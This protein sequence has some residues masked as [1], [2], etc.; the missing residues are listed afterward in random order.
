MDRKKLAEEIVSDLMSTAEPTSPRKAPRRKAVPAQTIEGDGNV[1]AGGGKALR[2]TIKGNGNVQVNGG[3]GSMTIRSTRAP[4]IEIAPAPGSIGADGV[5]KERVKEAFGALGTEREKRFGKSAYQ[6]MYSTFKKDFSIPKELP[7]TAIWDW[8]ASRADEVVAYLEAKYG[9]TIA[10][11]IERAA[12]KPGYQ[13]TRG[14]LFAREKELLD[15]LGF[16]PTSPE[17]KD[18]MRRLFGTDT[19]KDLDPRQHANWVA[20]IERWVDRMYESED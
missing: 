17:V 18:E 1:Q 11:K 6:V 16:K 4:K 20:H 8:P 5:L 15:H 12:K 2:Q 10:G 9:E 13:H 7:W 14:Q 19:H 3:I